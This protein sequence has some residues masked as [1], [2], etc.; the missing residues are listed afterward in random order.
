[1]KYDYEIQVSEEGRIKIGDDIILSFFRFSDSDLR[2][3]CKVPKDILI[4]R[5]ELF[6][7]YKTD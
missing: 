1:M 3:G 6:N 4:L 7:K 2:I 5:Q